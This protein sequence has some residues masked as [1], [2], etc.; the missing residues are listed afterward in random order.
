MRHGVH[1]TS[2]KHNVVGVGLASGFIEP[3]ESTGLL[4][5]H[6]NIIFLLRAL[7]R[8]DGQ[9]NKIDKD[10]W[11]YSVREKVENMREFVSQHY[12]LSSRHDTPYWKHV[13]EEISYDFG[14]LG[15]GDVSYP[16]T[17]SA[18][19]V[20]RLNKTFEFGPD[21]AGLMYI[22]TGNGYSP[23]S[24]MDYLHWE[25][26]VLEQIQEQQAEQK[27]KYKRFKEKFQVSLDQLPTHNEYLKENIYN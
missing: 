7:T 3:L 15:I 11:N 12:S 22:A 13:T 2:W 17:T 9:V 25:P 8:K 4:L 6:E 20:R 26:E 21:M 18:D 1:E 16:I 19:L 5:T 14:P 24:S 27:D 23:L 10:I